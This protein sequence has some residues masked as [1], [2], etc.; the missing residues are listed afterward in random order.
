MRNTNVPWAQRKLKCRWIWSPPS[1][2]KNQLAL[3]WLSS[4]KST[5]P[6]KTEHELYLPP[7]VSLSMKI[8]AQMK[9]GSKNTSYFS[10]SYGPLHFVT[11][12]SRVTRV[13]RS[14]LCEKRSA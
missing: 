8:C 3:N 2:T 13:S 11:S 7:D 12:H 5:P 14:T 1:P 9:T 4:S 10:P 6:T